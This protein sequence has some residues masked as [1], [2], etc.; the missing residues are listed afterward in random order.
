MV[1]F[2]LGAGAG[3]NATGF[4][5]KTPL[6]A[7]AESGIPEWVEL[8]CDRGANPLTESEAGFSTLVGASYQPRS[9]EKIRIIRSLV[10]RGVSLD[11]TSKHG[12]SPLSVT[13]WFGDFEAFRMLVELGANRTPLRLTDLHERIILG[14][15]EDL[16][17][18]PHTAIEI[19]QRD[20]RWELTPLLWAAK[21]GELEKVKHLV[22]LGATLDQKGRLGTTALSLAAGLDRFE[23]VEWLLAQGVDVDARDDNLATPLMSACA[24]GA[25]RSVRVLLDAGAAATARD[26]FA[27]DAIGHTWS[28]EV[29]KVLVEAGG[30]INQ[31]SSEGSWP[32][33]NAAEQNDLERCKW[34]IDHG[35]KV[36]LTSTGATALHSAVQG[37]SREAIRLL[38]EHG[39]D[40]NKQDVYGW[41]P[42]FYARSRETIQILLQSGADPKIQD[43]LGSTAE[44][45]LSDSLLRELIQ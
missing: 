45:W 12:E 20:G 9:P 14:S 39:A 5:G 42:L 30:D 15:I 36:E 28:L 29:L 26:N 41:T 21:T 13:L 17:A 32:L 27:N 8:L 11:R 7:A 2:L 25:L 34:L 16:K 6:H 3:V 38:L 31:I 43:D 37:D 22:K 10:E 19:D 40:P 4:L 24:A 1:E 33:M 44:K 23:V 35:A 18:Y